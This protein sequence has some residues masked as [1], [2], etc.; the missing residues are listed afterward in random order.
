MNYDGNQQM[1]QPENMKWIILVIDKDQKLI[2]QFY[3]END[4]L[5]NNAR[6]NQVPYGWR[7]LS[8]QLKT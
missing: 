4:Q 2:S 3:V 5:A 8:F 7:V 6:G 1:N